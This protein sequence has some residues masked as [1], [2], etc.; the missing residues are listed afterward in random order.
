MNSDQILDAAG[1]L[2][3]RHGVAAVGMNEI[4]CAQTLALR[5]SQPR[6]IRLAEKRVLSI[7]IL[8]SVKSRL[9]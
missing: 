6:S 1:E 7:I 9:T 2:F 8:K 5:Q 3:A 4:A